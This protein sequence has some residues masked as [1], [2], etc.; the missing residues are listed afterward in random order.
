[1]KTLKFKKNISL[2]VKE[3]SE[4][5]HKFMLEALDADDRYGRILDIKIFKQTQEVIEITGKDTSEDA[6]EVVQVFGLGLNGEI[7]SKEE[8]KDLL[9]CAKK[10]GNIRHCFRFLDVPKNT[11]LQKAEKK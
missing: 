2:K 4:K 10:S 6:M 9:Q 11:S 1:M 3:S 7:I 5:K 8:Y